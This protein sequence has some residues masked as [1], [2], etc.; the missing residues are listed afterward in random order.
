ME[1]RVTDAMPVNFQ[2]EWCTGKKSKIQ[3]DVEL[4]S[5]I[6]EQV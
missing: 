4:V 3:T 2:C 6:D 5:I 1:H